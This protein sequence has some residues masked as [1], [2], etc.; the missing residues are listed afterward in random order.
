VLSTFYPL[1]FFLL[2][3]CCHCLTRSLSPS[4]F[5]LSLH[6]S[7]LSPSFFS[8]SLPL[9]L[10]LSPIQ[11]LSGD[12]NDPR[13]QALREER[14]G[15]DEVRT[16]CS[17]LQAHCRSA[18]LSS[19]P[20]SFFSSPAISLHAASSSS[21][22]YSSFLFFVF[23]PPSLLILLTSFPPISPYSYLATPLPSPLSFLHFLLFFS[24]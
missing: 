1:P 15:A 6:L 10:S 9:S 13:L 22:S 23:L 5:S 4:L 8:L 14:D 7:S 18:H 12:V 21:Y 16:Q 11:L 19:P 24:L 3:D 17:T 20:L 2:V